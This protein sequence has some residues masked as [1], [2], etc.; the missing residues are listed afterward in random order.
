MSDA[1]SS[2]F[3]ALLLGAGL[4]YVVMANQFESLLH[5]LIIMFSIPF[6][7]IGLTAALLV[8]NTTFSL[9]AFIGAILLVGYVVNN[10]IVLVD[11]MNVLR[12][13]GISLE[14]AIT[15]GG[16]T[17]LKPIFMSTGTTALGLLPMALGIG[18]GAEL[19]APMARAVFG[20]LISSTLITL[21]LVPVIYYLVESKLRRKQPL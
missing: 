1:F 8:T 16:R 3:L 13:N 7:L 2:L 11:Y 12:R 6:A 15:I 10:A 21:I 5:P 19:R 18:T 4:V 14:K 20:G 17:R 9:V